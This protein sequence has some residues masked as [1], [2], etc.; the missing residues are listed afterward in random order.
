[1]GIGVVY[2]AKSGVYDCMN[3]WKNI[4]VV[5]KSGIYTGY[6]YSFYIFTIHEAFHSV[7]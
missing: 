6:I 1:M 4:G 7:V 5:Y 3:G 2:M